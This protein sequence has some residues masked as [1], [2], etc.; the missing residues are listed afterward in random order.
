[1]I[2]T[3]GPGDRDRRRPVRD[4]GPRWASARAPPFD[5]AAAQATLASEFN[6]SLLNL[7]PLVLLIILS[8]R[9]AP[10]FLRI[11]GVRPVRRRAGLVHPAA[12]RRGIRRATGDVA[13]HRHQGALHGDGQRVRVHDRR[14][15]RSTTLF[16]RGGMSS[17]LTTIWLVLGALSYAAIVERAGFLGPA[18]RAGRRRARS[19]PAPDRG[20]RLHGHRAQH[21]RR[22]PVRRDR[23]AQPR[24]PA[25]VPEARHRAADA[26]AH[27]RGRG[28]VTSPLVPWNSCG[29]YMAGVLGRAPPSRIC[30][31][32]S[33][34]C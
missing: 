31:T 24:L 27:R 16:S 6:I 28:T 2:W 18:H 14:S 19:R 3:S 7:L 17:M 21:R 1:M 11:F 22:R 33:S 13:G 9:R 34:T 4:P 10:P 20:S 32:A 30:R 25:R 29:A 8:L 5:R 15:S 23:H 26:V 12:A